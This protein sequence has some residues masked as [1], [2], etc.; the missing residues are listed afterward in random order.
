MIA[1]CGI[2]CI[3]CPAYIGT[4]T[5]NMVLLE[6]TA[7]KWSDDKCQYNPSDLI[8]NGCNSDKMHVF[9]LECKIRLCAKEKGNRV[10]SLCSGYPCKTLEEFWCSFTGHSVSGLKLALEQEKIRLV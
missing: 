6:E 4:Q 3:E 8:C 1:P 5:N 2:D 7:K 10:C 9:C